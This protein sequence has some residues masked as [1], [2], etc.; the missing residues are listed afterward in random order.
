MSW[1]ALLVA[2]SVMTMGIDPV[3]WRRRMRPERL[4]RFFCIALLLGV[5]LA[6]LGGFPKYAFGDARARALLQSV[7]DARRSSAHIR[8]ELEIRM[9]DLAPI[10]CQIVQSGTRGLFVSD[11]QGTSYHSRVLNDGEFVWIYDS[12]K[13]NDVR[14]MSFAKASRNGALYFDARTIGIPSLNSMEDSL[15]AL[16]WN[17]MTDFRYVGPEDLDGINC[18]RVESTRGQSLFT[19]WIDEPFARVL[20]RDVDAP[21]IHSTVKSS[22]PVG[23]R[24]TKQWV[25]Q[26]VDASRWD[27]QTRSISILSFSEGPVDDSEISLHAMEIPFGTAVMDDMVQ[28]RLGYWDGEKIVSKFPRRIASTANATEKQVSS[29]RWLFAI[30]NV[31]VFVI[32]GIVAG[33]L[34]YRRRVAAQ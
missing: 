10:R 22:Y 17:G 34:K 15:N 14:R 6:T 4:S 23:E 8:L 5:A 30:V 9:D 32:L 19:Y 13:L 25:P 20:R 3:T 33:I 1:P 12:G 27:G 21:G 24:F 16:I 26:S 18:L 28:R 31:S 11:Q 29:L 2:T 7:D